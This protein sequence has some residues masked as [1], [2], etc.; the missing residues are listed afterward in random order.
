M[1]TL[2][3][4]AVSGVPVMGESG[5]NGRDRLRK[6]SRK[7]KARADVGSTEISALG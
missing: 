3:L 1:N 4:H 5:V 7:W 2:T 6:Q